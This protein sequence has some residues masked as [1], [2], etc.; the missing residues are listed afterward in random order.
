MIKNILVI[1]FRRVGDSVLAVALCHSLKLSLPSAQVH[2]VVNANI[3]P[4]YEGHPDIDRVIPFTEEEQH[5]MAYLKKVRQI[6]KETRYD[7]IIDMRSTVKTLPFALFS[8]HTPYLIGRKKWYTTFIHRYRLSTP[9][10]ADRVASNLNLMTPFSRE[11][12]IVR[13]EHFPLYIKEKELA[14]YRHYL[15][16]QG[17]DLDKPVMLCAV[18]TRIEGKSWPRERMTEILRRIVQNYD[19]QLIF[20]YAGEIEARAAHAYYDALD[21]HRSIFLG[22]EAKGLRQ[23][24]ALCA[25]SQFFFGNEGGPRHISQA[26]D[27]PSF[28]IYPPGIDKHFWLP[29]NN[30]R[31]QGISPDDT[32]TAEEQKHMSYQERMALITV[33]NVWAGL[34]PMLDQY[35]TNHENRI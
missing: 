24:C 20:N 13:D 5:G 10:G 34:K 7:A 6:V 33:E 27:V 26:F 4:L 15:Q 25:T 12:K 17:I 2:Y 19:V 35:L 28:A 23:L 18:T 3:A 9:E 32:A 11:V 1:R 30:E 29:G 16:E 31:Y 8:R 22:I 14:D 21:H